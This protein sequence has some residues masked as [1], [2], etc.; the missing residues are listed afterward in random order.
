MDGSL[1]LK[2]YPTSLLSHLPCSPEVRANMS[3]GQRRRRER[4]RAQRQASAP[5]GLPPGSAAQA[6]AQLIQGLARERAVMELSRLRRELAAWLPVGGWSILA[7]V[8]VGMP[9]W[10]R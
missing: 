10:L 1:P 6:Q 5:G 3:A 9:L 8:S 2:P 4:E 7:P